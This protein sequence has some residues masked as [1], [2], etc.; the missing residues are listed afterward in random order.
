MFLKKCL[1]EILFKS[2]TLKLILIIAFSISEILLLR[3]EL[4]ITAVALQSFKMVLFS[5]PEDLG[6]KG[7]SIKPLFI[8][9]NET[10]TRFEI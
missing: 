1:L 8:Q 4:K 3:D 10:I 6:F 9:Y 2:S 7:T 5:N